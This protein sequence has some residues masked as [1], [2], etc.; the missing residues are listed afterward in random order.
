M[1]FTKDKIAGLRVY[2]PSNPEQE[3]IADCLTSLD[4]LITAQTQRVETLKSHKKSLMQ[5]LFPSA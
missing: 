4:A 5:G 3:K 2:I 1:G